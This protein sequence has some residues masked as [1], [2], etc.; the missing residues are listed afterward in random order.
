M[1]NYRYEPDHIET[2]H[3]SYRSGEAVAVSPQ[4]RELLTL[5]VPVSKPKA[6][7]RERTAN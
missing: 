5:K 4:V 6:N 2:N 1:L 3:E 7:G